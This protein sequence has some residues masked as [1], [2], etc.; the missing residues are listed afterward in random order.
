MSNENDTRFDLIL[1]GGH[2]ID[3][4]NSIDSLRD[5]AI[6]EGIIAEVAKNIPVGRASHVIDV[7]G[8]LISPGL[9][10]IHTHAYV[11]RQ[12]QG[13][14]FF[15]DSLNADAHFL[16]GG[17]TTAVD[18]GTAGAQEISHFRKSVMEKTVCRI[19]AFVNIS[20]PGMGDV[21]QNIGTF[22]VAAAAKAVT[23]N[24]EYV[25]GIKTA[26][27][28]TKAPFDDDHPPWESVERAVE[29]GD[30]CGMPVMVDFWPRPPERPYPE[31]ILKKLRPGDIHTHVFARQFPIVDDNGRVFKYMFEARERGVWFDLGHGAASFWFRN[32][33]RAIQDGFSPDSISTDLHM[34]NIHGSVISMLD[35]MSK[36]L[37]MGMPV[38]EVISKST[39]MPAVAIGRPELG[40]LSVG[41]EADVALLRLEKGTFSYRDCGFGRMDGEHRLSC[42]MTLRKGNVVWDRDARTTQRWEELPEDYWE[43]TEVPLP[44]QR[45]WR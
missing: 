6:S 22:D 12:H 27:Y 26:H 18:T 23:E 11:N 36:C 45:H 43:V 1:Q 25:V 8:L 4:K 9:I 15:A 35:T 14:G 28:W 32:G 29:A 21:E 7:S 16:S 40:T 30:A 42:V 41:A 33:A 37:V 17:V 13:S 34:G 19:L 20:S 24:S 44:I 31:L 5:V 3:P 38:P 39:A 10:D 2:V